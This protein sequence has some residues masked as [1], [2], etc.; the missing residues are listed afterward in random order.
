MIQFTPDEFH[1]VREAISAA[2][3]LLQSITPLLKQRHTTLNRDQRQL[4]A[5]STEAVPTAF[6]TIARITH[7][8][9]RDPE[10]EENRPATNF[11]D[12][13]KRDMRDELEN[14]SALVLPDIVYEMVCALGELPMFHET[15]TAEPLTTHRAAILMAWCWEAGRRY[16]I[17][18]ALA[19]LD[20]TVG[21]FKAQTDAVLAAALNATLDLPSPESA[22]DAG[23]LPPGSERPGDTATNG[24]AGDH[25]DDAGES[26][27]QPKPELV[28]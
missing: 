6:N 18:Q 17:R 3:L 9:N 8:E 24:E 16:G 27:A 28:N 10:A 21:D 20:N 23:K 11:G 19:I 13:D 15:I 26:G 12:I 1:Q 25:G 2:H 14:V 5:Y 7:R 4:L 22:T